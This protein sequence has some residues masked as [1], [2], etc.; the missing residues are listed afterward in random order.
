MRYF[1]PE[2]W[3][4]F[5]ADHAACPRCGADIRAWNMKGYLDKLIGALAH[6]DSETV[7]R[8][9]W[10][11]GERREGGAVQHLADQVRRTTNVYVARAAVRAIGAIG[12]DEALTALA[13]FTNHPAEMVRAEVRRVVAGR[14]Q[15][16]GPGANK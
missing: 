3:C 13:S 8:A 10:V 12:S 2:C 4:D 1:C 6:P 5:P 16:R 7:M 14:G 9:A 15:P 11:M